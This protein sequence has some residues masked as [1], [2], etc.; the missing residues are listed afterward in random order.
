MNVQNEVVR[1]C[2]REQTKVI[3]LKKTWWLINEPQCRQRK[4][5]RVPQIKTGNQ[6]FTSPGD[7][8]GA[9]NNHFTNIGQSLALGI[10]S[11]DTDSL[12][13]A[14]PATE[15]FLANG[16]MFNKSSIYLKLLLL[17]SY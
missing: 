17:A 14:N 13:Y 12:S 8:A 6:I 15:Y 10:S 16:S 4:S 7:L 1:E 2:L 5:T 3:L 11:V 9:F